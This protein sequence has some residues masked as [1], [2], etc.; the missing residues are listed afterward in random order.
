MSTSFFEKLTGASNEEEIKT[1][2]PLEEPE[3]PKRGRPKKKPLI[4]E[5]EIEKETLEIPQLKT[6]SPRVEKTPKR[7]Q[8]VKKI[9]TEIEGKEKDWLEEAEGEEEG[10]LTIDVY[11]TDID[12]IIKSTIAGVNPEDIDVSITNDMVTIRGKRTKDESV[13][14]ENYYYQELYWGGFSR[15]IIL[16]VEVDTDKAKASIKNGILTVKLPKSEKIKTKKI[17]VMSS[18]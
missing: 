10:Q 2:T 4:E 5:K 9:E 12:I 6:D 14:A 17:K 16:P 13:S 15:S 8:S 3:K 18:L 11:Q 1:S 7:K